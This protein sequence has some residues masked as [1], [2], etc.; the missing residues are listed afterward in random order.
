MRLDARLL[1]IAGAAFALGAAAWFLGPLLLPVRVPHDF[2]ALPALQTLNPGFRTLLEKADRDAR[3]KP[4]SPEAAG[5]LGM[6]YHANMMFDHAAR[7]YRIAA[8]LAPGDPQWTY[9][10]AFL[11]EETGAEKQQIAFLE[12]TLR[13]AP[14]HAPAL[15]KL[16]DWHFKSDRLDQAGH[17]YGKA[18][19]TDP[20]FQAALPASFGL[21]RVAARREDWNKVLEMISPLTA[22]YPHAAPLY[23]LLHEAYMALGQPQKAEEAAR[24][25]AAAKWKIVPPFMD[26]FNDQLT[27][28][29]YSSTRLL[30]QAGLLSRVG[31]ADRAIEVAR[32][33]AEAEPGDADVRH[34]LARTLLTFYPDQPQ[35]IDEALNHLNECLRL[36]P[37]DPVPLG[38]FADD[39]FKSPKPRAAVE[40]LRSLLRSRSDIPGGRFF[41]AMAADELGEAAEAASLYR[42]ALKENPKNAA[43]Y[44]KLGLLSERQGR[45]AEAIANFRK[46]IQ[47]S[48]TNTAARL[49]L[50]I[51]LLREGNF[52]GGMAELE[53]ILRMNPH[54]AAAHFCMGFALLSANRPADAIPRFREGLLYNPADAEGHYGLGSALAAQGDPA[55]AAELREAL[56]LNPNHRPAR[57]LLSRLQ[58]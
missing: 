10:Q 6:V 28:L 46:A 34:F 58:P 56:R 29:S 26:P 37:D 30:K 22:S 44:N 27:A 49:N 55:A 51:E 1:Q 52:T 18:A 57:Q 9:A 15:L 11:H 5:R 21:A 4:A 42:A 2:P 40:R 32:R 19:N 20:A 31:Q 25:A 41:L 7:A 12:Q 50:A 14:S 3:R 38:G 43:A 13:L 24:L 39:F 35:A 36:R 45:P 16:A 54:D 53:S 17:Y 48:P 23:E 47:L 8:R 33:A